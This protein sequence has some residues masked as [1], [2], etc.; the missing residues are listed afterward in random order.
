[1]RI[2]QKAAHPLPRPLGYIGYVHGGF[3]E[4]GSRGV[5]EGEA[6]GRK[7]EAAGYAQDVTR[8]M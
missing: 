7:G 2:A 4:E 5:G 8:G 3:G 6:M 1:M